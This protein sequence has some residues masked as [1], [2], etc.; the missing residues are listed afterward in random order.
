MSKQPVVES[1][2]D[3]FN[4][5][6]KT[7][8]SESNIKVSVSVKNYLNDLLQFYIL[9]D[10]L[11]S[12]TNSSGKK[13]INTIAELYLTRNISKV[14]TKNQLKKIGDTSLYLSGFFRESLKRKMISVDYYIQMGQNA[15][16]TLGDLQKEGDL[17]KELAQHF[18]DLVF[19]LFCIYKKSIGNHYDY[20]LSLIDQYMDTQSNKVAK[21]LLSHGIHI[22][23]KNQNPQ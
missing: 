19:V 17:F 13:Q 10:H 15:Y 20:L 1:T 18:T 5:L 22:P 23:F 14:N 2:K 16:E 11:F 3:F 12:E 9:S 21:E 6:I 4:V 8:L 7:G